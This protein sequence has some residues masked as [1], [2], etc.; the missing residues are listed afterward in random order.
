MRACISL[1]MLRRISGGAAAKM[2][3]SRRFEGV[4]RRRIMTGLSANANV[5][6][7]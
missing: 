6:L 1:R 5:R 7:Q 3:A 2:I 4:A